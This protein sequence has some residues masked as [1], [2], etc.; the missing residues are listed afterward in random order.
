[1]ADQQWHW[2]AGGQPGGVGT[3][4]E[5]TGLAAA[6]RVR[7]DDQVWT[8]GMANWE[9]ARDVPAVAAHLPAAGGMAV[10]G[11]GPAGAFPPP[12]VAAGSTPDRIGYYSTGGALPPRAADTLRGHGRPAGDV[13]DWPLDDGRMDQLG[14]AAK[15]RKRVT[16]A[17][18]LIRSLAA[19]S[20][21]GAVGVVF[22]TVAAAVNPRPFRG[23]PMMGLLTSVAVQVGSTVLMFLAARA[24]LRSQRWGA[25]TALVLMLL[26]AAGGVLSIVAGVLGGRTG[27][28]LVVFGFVEVIFFGL[29][30]ISPIRALAAIPEYLRQP[31][32]CQEVLARLDKR[33]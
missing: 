23:T 14:A 17:A 2:T 18:T 33:K 29:L 5:L 19:L 26:G 25:I 27:T 11:V 13:G 8:D 10:P 15:V 1:M 31:A 16:D 7:G 24:T 32:W 21:I 22:L 4:A 9:A 28:P 6:G 30:S 20:L 3:T 12:R